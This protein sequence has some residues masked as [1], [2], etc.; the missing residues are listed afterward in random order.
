MNF[1]PQKFFIGLTDFFSILLP[2]ALLSGVLL[3]EMS[4]PNHLGCKLPEVIVAGG[5][6]AFFLASYLFGHLLFLLG[7][8]LDTFYDWVRNYTLN[9]QI[10][11]LARHG[12]LLPWITRAL[13]WLVFK[14]ERNIAVERA[15]AIKHMALRPLQAEQSVNTFQWCKALLNIESPASLAVVQRFE[16]DSKFFR[17]LA[18]LLGVLFF[19]FPILIWRQHSFSFRAMSELALLIL[20]VL[21]L[22]RYMD[23]RFKATNQAYFA[24]ITISARDGKTLVRKAPSPAAPTHAGGVV[25]R[26]NGGQEQYLLL[27]SRSNAEEWVLPKGHI[28]EMERP[29]ET[30]V[31]EVLEETG[32]GAAIVSE[33]G[34]VSNP[35]DADR[36]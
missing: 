15:K 14:D 29:S 18:F 5:W 21:S 13:I 30:A 3:Y 12:K 24:V 35:V 34:D 28:E 8:W 36:K 26:P 7:S 6:V 33:L 23:Q 27:E 11:L 19:L 25:F 22:W 17:S 20:F 2:G 31:R 32:V 10:R 1:E 4:T 16:A 9:A